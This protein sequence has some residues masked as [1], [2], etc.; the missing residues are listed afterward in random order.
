LSGVVLRCPNCG[1]TQAA[2]GQC[3]A[4]HE[5]SVRYFCRNH[6]PGVWLEGEACPQCGARFGDPEPA[7]VEAAPV[8]R[9][10]FRPPPVRPAP[11]RPVDPGAG[12]GPWVIAH[13]RNG[14]TACTGAKVSTIRAATIAAAKPG[15]GGATTK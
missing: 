11:Y 8:E 4:C 5:A 15:S 3:D 14:C 6:N 7:R 13:S 1:T 9:P 2:E 10:E 12:L